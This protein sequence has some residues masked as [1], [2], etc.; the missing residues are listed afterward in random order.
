MSF[1]TVL[2]PTQSPCSKSSVG[3]ES[4]KVTTVACQLWR[5]QSRVRK[6]HGFVKWRWLAGSKECNL[7]DNQFGDVLNVGQK[8]CKWPCPSSSKRQQVKPKM[9][10]LRR[11]IKKENVK[12]LIFSMQDRKFASYKFA[13]L[14]VCKMQD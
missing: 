8:V 4:H 12:L 3:I 7:F 1:K 14:K 2:H 6:L 11:S 13:G 5:K 9:E 10:A